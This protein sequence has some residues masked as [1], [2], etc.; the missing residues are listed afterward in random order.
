MSLEESVSDDTDA[1]MSPDSPS[2]AKRKISESL[3]NRLKKMKLI[4]MDNFSIII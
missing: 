1:K 2:C 3:W 4:S